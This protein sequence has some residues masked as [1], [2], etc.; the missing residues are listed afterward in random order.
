MAEPYII[1]CWHC[2][3]EFDALSAS[4]CN[5]A[6]PTKTC[7]FCLKCFCDAS[8]DY[9]KKYVK[10]CPKELLAIYNEAK[11]SLYLKIGE[12]LVKA[13]KI[14]IEQLAT[15]LDKQHIVNL[16]LGE[17]LIIMS[18]VTPDELQLYLLNQ[19]SV[20]TID[21]KNLKVD[22]DLI[23]QI[24]KEFCLDQKIVPIEIQEIAGGRM[25][26]FAFYSSSELPKL[27]KSSE[28]QNFKLIPYLAPKE[29]IENILKNLENSERDI[30]IYTSLASARHLKLLNS[31]IKSAVQGKVSDVFFEFKSGKLKIFFRN[32]ELLSPVNQ[33]SEDPKEFFA[34]IKE[35]C[36]IKPTTKNAAQESL[37]NLNKNLSYLKIKVLFYLGSAQESIR[38]KLSNLND[39]A[40]KIT[41][42]NLESDELDRLRAI[43][44]KPNGL[45]VVAGPGYSKANE[46]L[47]ALMN[48]L[49]SE[50]IATVEN[51]VI[52]RNERFF[53]SENKG[54]DVTN[55]VYKN[56]LF[57][58]PDSMFLFDYFQKNYDSQFL[59][60]VEMGKLFIEL[61]GF[62]YEEIFEKMKKEYEIPLSYLAENLRLLI[63][64]RQ[65][66]ILCP[67]C[68]M[69]NPRPAR[70]LFKNKSL[71]SNYQIFQEKGCP[72]CQSSGYNRD[73]IFYEIFIMDNQEKSFFKEEDLFSLDNKISEAGNL[74]I[75]Q[76]ILNRVLKGEISYQESCRFF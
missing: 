45:F 68:K 1:V 26:R 9:K 43:L 30:K 7:P 31:L 5:H 29:E 75:S 11:D 54:S 64:Q 8:E 25:L 50:R 51:D 73:E 67:I 69:P 62:S 41:N 38:F 17:I 57:F 61:Q 28:L 46:T 21:L 32:G 36:G 20:E 53:Q 59:H 40:K 44:E 74:T 16:K 55:A 72:E 18:L 70:E 19:K 76:K 66:K 27:K 34:K 52:L 3:A 47:Y 14:S 39:F 6:N 49:V 23:H 60:F 58:K 63:F 42:L 22:S 37:L 65:A 71:S 10:N 15:A 33:P 4:D 2:Q 48:T 35:I 56:L 24:G 12:I 13:G